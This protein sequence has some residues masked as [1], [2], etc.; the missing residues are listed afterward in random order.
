VNLLPRG[1]NEPVAPSPSALER[2]SPATRA[3][4][5]GAFAA[6]TAAQEGAWEAISSGRDTLVVA[7]TGS[8]KTL[9]AFL[10]SLDRLASAP[11]PEEPR[12][13]CRVLYVSP[14]KAL[15]VDV[16]RNLR[17]PLTGIRQAAQR[18]DLPVPDLTVGIRSG[19]TPAEERRRFNK[20]PPDVFIT[21]PESLF[22]VLTSAA[23]DSL[24]GVETVIVDEVHAVS[25]S[26][27]GAHLA[28]SLE[29]LDELLERP[30]Q[31]IGLS[32]TVR[33]I[34]E[35]ARFLG[36]SREVVVV[37]PPSTKTIEVQV[38]VPVEDMSALGESAGPVRGGS[39]AGGQP[40]ASIWPAI[41][42]RIV[43]LVEQYRATLV[44]SNSRRSAERLTSRLNEIATERRYGASVASGTRHAGASGT[45]HEGQPEPVVLDT[46][47]PAGSSGVKP[48]GI[49]YPAAHPGQGGVGRG[50]APWG[51]GSPA[52]GG[53]LLLASGETQSVEIARAHHGS[54]SREQRL[55]IEEALKSGR[56][57]A[58]VAT[59]SLEL[60]IDMGAVDLVVQVESPPSVASG[61][62]RI[63]RAGHQ[64]GAV[65]RG[66]VLPKY[67][68]DLVQCAVVAERMTD[69]AIEATSYPRNPLDVLA[70]QVVAMCALESWQVDELAAVVRRA[71]PFASLPQSALEAVLDMLSGRYPSDEFAELR[72]RITWDRATG[73]LAGRPGAQR[74]AVTSG[75]TIPDRGMFGVFLVGSPSS[76]ASGG[77]SS[78]RVGELDEEMVYESRVGD[79]FLLGSSAWRIEDITHD[80]VLVTPA[81]GQPGRMPYWHGDAPGRPVELGRA[82]GAFL[83]EL[84]AGTPADAERRLQEAGLDPHAVANLLAYL[85]EQR[86]ATGVLPDDR[87]ILVE[88]F[89]D[90]LG[91]W[92]LAIHSPFGAQVNQPWALALTARLRERYGVDVQSM[93]SDDGI[94]LR[95]PETEEP[96]D[97][98][99]A[100]F[101]PDE[102]EPT[103]QAEVG[104]SALF[105]SRFRECAARALLLPRRN[106]TRRTPLWQQRQRSAQLLGVAAQYGSFPVVLETMR[107]VLQDV[108]DVPGLVQLMR[109]VESRAVRLVEVET[110]QPSPFARSLLFGYIGAFMYEGDAP[111]AERRAQALSLDSALL[112]ELLGQAELRELIDA[113]ALAEVEA[114]VQ[115]LTPE[116]RAKDLEGVAD[117]LRMLG[118]LTTEEVVA[119][120][121]ESAWLV[122]LEGQRRALRVRVAGQER[123]VAVED[124][125][126]LRDALGTA[127]PVGVAEAFL[128][129][130][131]DPV[132]DLVSRFARTH[133]PFPPTEVAKRFGLGT[134]VVDGALARL[135]TRGR[136]VHGEFRPGG[137][138]LEWCDAE[139]LRSLRRRSLAKLR[140]E[141]EPVP[142]Q[143]LARFLPQWQGV[144]ASS[145]RG[146]DALVRAVEQL[147]G[148]SVPASALETL[149]LPSRVPGYTPSMLDE[150]T[151]SGEVLWAGQGTLPGKD[152]WVSL[153]LADSADLLLPPPLDASMTP[154][155]DAVLETV[156]DGSA[157]FFR[158][159]SDRVGSLDAGAVTDGALQTA[160]W[161]LVWA[162]HL[163]NDTLGPLRALLG[164]GRTAHAQ[165]RAP[166][167][168]RSRY[169][170]PGMPTRTGPPTVAGRWSRLPD[171]DVD[172]TRRT[173][174]LAE[175]LLDRHGVVTRGTVTAEHAPGGFAAV[176]AVLK[177]FEEAGRVRR[178]YFV[179]GLG[180]AQFAAPG[181]V[182]RMRALAAAHPASDEPRRRDE[183]RA[184][185]LAAADP[186]NPY[187]GALPWPQ[188]QGQGGHK[189]G[190]K[191]GALVV[192]VEGALVL[193]VE[194]GGRTL[195]SFREH[196]N[197][198]GP[199]VDALALAVREGALG[200]LTVTKA[201]GEA[202]L[203]S[204]LG[205]A[206]EAA[207]FRPTPRGLRLR[208]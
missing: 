6:P 12:H 149:V 18:L 164:S 174:A 8:G 111:L 162:G 134:A 14:L 91:D 36:G 129:P 118:D 97:G 143:A 80:R 25:G 62:Q 182:D 127:L 92:R 148:A 26:K 133:G 145:G 35:V 72:P 56:L 155:H 47:R 107:E 173:H 160:L 168:Q 159:L 98:S 68:G 110:T 50:S 119:R 87:T 123:W 161:D 156:A 169:G 1:E 189:P 105:A 82:L 176:Y 137:T 17:A 21:T 178:G 74:L 207:G 38:V 108:F 15:A 61:L 10:W 185:V 126:R 23:R 199:A 103:V 11:P 195:L 24:R 116:R 32:A 81:P 109:E 208:A 130:V 158:Q 183:V 114:E 190:R 128:E 37:Q 203:T 83:R 67:R 184:V 59:S 71:A 193:Y 22:L 64:V 194:R 45:R 86:E 41:E 58:V 7:P 171:R 112:S 139:V 150:L 96:P 43:D 85:A 49:R 147:Q 141:V 55:S 102:V 131:K 122:E 113:D 30:A 51:N 20:V 39:A 188:P 172:P 31:R 53:P 4:F 63:G 60:G 65:S 73:T 93:H 121:G 205:L 46:E 54:V 166:V 142:P 206:L 198:L 52:D 70:Q 154:L 76:S 140:Q 69:G 5:S 163:T 204:P 28:L 124:A 179:E 99:V 197:C 57:P 115:R 101:A 200:R 40:R 77:T 29:R 66:I 3:W 138:G 117:L 34:D 89:R 132:G 42:E 106:P 78:S 120:G 191:A 19:D 104:G 144:T 136:V 186:A 94:V 180:A 165:K 192:L 79:V 48:D 187:G 167:R 33:P 151:A 9:S 135:A 202:A 16:E 88:R 100:V 95:L 146:L 170:R 181:A 177:A 2:F 175:V 201:D 84:S 125:G 13:R 196:D 152:G 44:F 27:R 90:E 75:G 157:L 153:Q